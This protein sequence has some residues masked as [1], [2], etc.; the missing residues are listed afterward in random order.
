M[1]KSTLIAQYLVSG[2]H[3]SQLSD[4]ELITE[5]FISQEYP[6]LDY[7]QWNTSLNLA[8]SEQFLQ[9]LNFSS[10]MQLQQLVHLLHNY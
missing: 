7:E 9:A 4:A 2:G 1:R 8:Q 5:R 6:Q 10:P 3:V